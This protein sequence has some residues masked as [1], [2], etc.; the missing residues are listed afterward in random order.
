[1]GSAIDEILQSRRTAEPEK[2]QEPQENK[3]YSILV[4]EGIEEHFLELRFN[5]GLRSCFAY[6]DL[7]WFNLDPDA[8][9]IDLNIGGYAIVIRGR[10]LGDKLFQGIKRKRLSWVQEAHTELQDN[11][12][13]DVFISSISITPPEGFSEAEGS[14]P[15]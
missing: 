9:L 15:E 8:G 5:S 12:Q 11:D 3:F 6:S 4:G 1:M 7:L 13:A 2:S 14:E 10:G